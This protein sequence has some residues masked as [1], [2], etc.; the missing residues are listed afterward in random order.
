[1]ERNDGG[2][3]RPQQREAR[4]HDTNVTLH[5]DPEPYVRNRPRGVPNLQGAEK[6]ESNDSRDAN[7]VGDSVR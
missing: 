2:E 1:M 6:R 7:A 3:Y 5:V 4:T